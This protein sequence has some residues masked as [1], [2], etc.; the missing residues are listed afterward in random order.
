M[1]FE[2]NIFDYV[3]LHDVLHHID[4][5]KQRREKHIDGLRELRRVCK[6]GGF[7]IIVEANRYNLLFY[8]H[9]TLMK[10][11]EH[12]KQSYFI[13]I[14]KEL[15]KN[16]SIQFRFFEAHLYPPRFLKMFKVYEK[17]IEKFSFLE[18]FLAYN[19]AITK[20]G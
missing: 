10:G 19:V 4:E 16:D 5:P 8:P 2:D 3:F 13:D 7:I 14:I 1:P 20:I 15:F 18:P 6:K 9:M 17:V 12:F 11:H